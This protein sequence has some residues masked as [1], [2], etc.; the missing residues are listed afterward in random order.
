MMCKLHDA[1]NY[2][3]LTKQSDT[4]V[5]ESEVQNHARRVGFQF[6]N[7]KVIEECSN[8]QYDIIDTND[9][10]KKKR[11]LMFFCS[12]FL[13]LMIMKLVFCCLYWRIKSLVGFQVM[14][15]RRMCSLTIKLN[16]KEIPALL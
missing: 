5:P 12:K 8:I 4:Q 10:Y 1:T 9:N 14:L 2:F 11:L 15:I 3:S 16:L 6:G 7:L 13:F